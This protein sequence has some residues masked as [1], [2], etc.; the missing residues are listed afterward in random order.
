MRACIKELCRADYII[1]LPGS[2]NSRGATLEKEIAIK[3]NI[4]EMNE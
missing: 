2:E 4:R 1:F 3:L